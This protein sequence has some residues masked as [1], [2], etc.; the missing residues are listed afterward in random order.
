[1]LVAFSRFSLVLPTKH[2]VFFC[3]KLRTVSFLPH[4]FQFTS[5]PIIRRCVLW[6]TESLINKI[7]PVVSVQVWE[8]KRGFLS[9]FFILCYVVMQSSR[10]VLTFRRNMVPALAT[11]T[12]KLETV[13]SSET[14]SSH[15][16][17][18]EPSWTR[19]LPRKPQTPQKEYLLGRWRV[20]HRKRLSEYQ[21]RSACSLTPTSSCCS[22][23]PN[24]LTRNTFWTVTIG[25][26]FIWL[27]HVGVNQGMMQRFLALPTLSDARWSV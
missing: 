5:H 11:R 10:E 22:M 14:F 9:S 16:P 3:V 21:V 24:P 17:D 15:L 4:P 1:M 8:T 27:S 19:P 25:M 2:R 7:S 23:D 6:A 12:P 18:R 13:Y 20:G 26:T